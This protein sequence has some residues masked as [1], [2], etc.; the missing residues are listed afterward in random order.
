MPSPTERGSKLYIEWLEDVQ[1][2][3]NVQN[4]K[5]GRAFKQCNIFLEV[6]LTFLFIVIVLSQKYPTKSI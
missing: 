3:T 2:V 5:M 6:R 1:N 4:R